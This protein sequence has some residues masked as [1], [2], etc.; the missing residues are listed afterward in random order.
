MPGDKKDP[1]DVE[2]AIDRLNDALRLQFRSAL[3]F[4]RA[5][6]AMT[7]FEYQGRAPQ[8]W[9]YAEL[10]LADARRL[11]EKIVALG[12]EPT[13]KVA[14]LK[15]RDAP[16]AMVDWLVETEAEALEALQDVIPTTGHTAESEALE[17][18]M[19]HLILRKQSQVDTLLRAKSGR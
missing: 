15:H 17:H 9:E 2:A 14:D 6:G 12:G 4:A 19:E 16:E 3:G 18:L 13:T 10:E 11:V 5:A 1:L 8:L 7:G